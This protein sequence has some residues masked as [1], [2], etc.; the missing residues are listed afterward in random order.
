[1]FA[2]YAEQIL[3][4]PALGQE[5][6]AA[7]ASRARNFTWSTAAARLRRIYADLTARSPNACGAEA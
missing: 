4:N 3:D 5:L 2:A 7:A 1:V 6:A